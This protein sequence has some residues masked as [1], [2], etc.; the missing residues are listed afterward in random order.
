MSVRSAAVLAIFEAAAARHAAHVGGM[1]DH[2]V[3]FV[4]AAFAAA[5]PDEAPSEWTFDPAD[6]PWIGDHRPTYG[7][8]V[9]PAAWLFD[10]LA[11][12]AARGRPIAGLEDA[13]VLGWAPAD[14]PIR[15]RVEVREVGGDRCE[16]I[17]LAYRSSSRAGLSRFEPRARAIVRLGQ[18]PL[19]ASAGLPT[20]EPLIA[21]ERVPNPYDN[22]FLGP[23]FQVV[24]SMT[25]GANGASTLVDPDRSQVPRG[26]LGVGLLDASLHAAIPQA[27]LRWYPDLGSACFPNTI[28]RLDFFGPIPLRGPVRVELRTR[29][30]SPDG[31]FS[32][33]HMRYFGS[34]ARH[35]SGAP[36][37]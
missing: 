27:R 37:A 16:A 17:L 35:P 25:L 12:V 22:V 20:L 7:T 21:P 2:H 9:L 14:A 28:E 1:R 24:T 10:R 29:G 26:R 23:A 11:T 34:D 31:R 19:V 36:A 13:R 5:A 33:A 6:N 3:E 18:P 32:R 8:P 4:R 30:A 15:F